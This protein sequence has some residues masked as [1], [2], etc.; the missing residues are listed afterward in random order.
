VLKLTGIDLNCYKAPQMQ[1][2]LETFLKRSNNATWPRLFRNLQSDPAA[3][4]EFKDYLTIN[5]TS[6]FRDPDKYMYLQQSILPDLWRGRNSLRVW[7]AGCSRGQEAYSL[8]ILLAESA[9]KNQQ[10][11]ILATDIDHSALEWAKAGGPYL[12]SEMTN[13]PAKFH[14]TYF[15]VRSNNYWI[16]NAVRFNIVFRHHNLLSDPITGKFDLIVCRNVVIYFEPEAKAKL[17][18]RFYDALRPGGVLFVGGTELVFKAAEIGFEAAGISF[19]RRK[20]K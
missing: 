19:Y 6:L 7:S 10:Y 3:L 16:N 12:A 13:V 2:R 14:Q 8:A 20:T 9:A 4:N 5:V 18:C 15:N 11:R 1:R 17:Y